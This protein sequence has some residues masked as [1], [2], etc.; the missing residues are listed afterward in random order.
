MPCGRRPSRRSARR[1]EKLF[2]TDATRFPVGVTTTYTDHD[3]GGR[4]PHGDGDLPGH[5]Q[6][7]AARRAAASRRATGGHRGIERV[8]RARDPE[9][10][11]VD[12]ERG[13][14]D[15]A[16]AGRVR[17]SED[18][19]RARDARVRSA[20]ATAL[21]VSRLRARARGANRAGRSRDDGARRG[22]SRVAHPD[23]DAERAGQLRRRP[24]ATP[25]ASKATKICCTARSS[26]SR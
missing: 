4:R 6:P 9:S 22:K 17:R 21:R 12:P 5:L 25:F 15:L 14:A 24:R 8:A 13:G 23:R 7:E 20:V 19:Q 11:G 1:A 18:A 26:I 2:V 16:H 3:D 10:A